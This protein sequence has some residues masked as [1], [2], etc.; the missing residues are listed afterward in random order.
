M[1]K[2]V[3]FV[4]VASL[5]GLG[6]IQYRFLIIGLRFSK[7]RFDMKMGEALQ[8]MRQ[9]L[10][11]EN[12][13]TLLLA[14]VVREDAGD[15]PVGIDTLEKASLNYLGDFLMDRL[16]GKGVNANFDFALTNFNGEKIYLKT[17]GF[18]KGNGFSDYAVQLGGHVP[19]QCNCGVFLR[20]KPHNLINYL[21]SQLNN[22]IIPSLVFFALIAGCFW[23]LLRFL[24]RQ[25]RLDAIK[26]DFINNL[27]HELK[28]PVFTIGLTAKMLREQISDEKGREYLSVISEENELLKTHIEKVL[29]LASLESSRR[30]LDRQLLDVHSILQPVVAGFQMQ[31]AQKGGHFHF[32]PEAQNPMARIDSAHL[33]N[34][35]LNLLDNAL[36]YSAQT[37]DIELRTY[38]RDGMLCIAVKD[39]GKGIPVADQKKVF[40]KFFRVS[41]G[42]LHEVKGFGLGLSYVSQ[43]VRLHGGRIRLDSEIGKGSTFTVELPTK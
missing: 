11:P 23:W 26:N 5:L 20:L 3:V 22:L 29:E 43:V 30:V 41:N 2:I 40:Q 10:Y 1:R 32:F 28:T 8:E 13:L 37:I 38:N 24:S 21:L 34:A 7:T 42:D 31:A 15:F 25:R 6:L 4:L 35:V 27:T 33:G 9:E 18:E 14:S 16:M 19:R 36:K 17:E 39:Q 12:A